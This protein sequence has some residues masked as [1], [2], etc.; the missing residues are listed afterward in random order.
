MAGVP[1]LGSCGNGMSHVERAQSF[2]AKVAACSGVRFQMIKGH[3]W[4]TESGCERVENALAQL[5]PSEDVHNVE[6]TYGHSW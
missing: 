1:G 3:Q 6:T 4:C 5:R 2:G